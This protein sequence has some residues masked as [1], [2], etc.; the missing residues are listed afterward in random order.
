[1][2]HYNK[3]L[4][5]P[6]V[7]SRPFWDACRDHKL[8]CQKC[9]DCGAFRFPPTRI[10]PQCLGSNFAWVEMTGRG[11]V[12]SFTIFRRLYHPGF[13]D[14]IPYV[15]AVVALDEGPRMLS[16][17]V[18]MDVDLVRC[19]MPVQVRFDKATDDITI[20]KFTALQG[21]EILA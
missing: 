16:N 8:I 3:P 18:G 21:D 5:V 15:V 19:G 1:M 12:F 14:D 20:P 4:P 11:E 17:V 13:A 9:T 10:C 7:E 6:S 2:T